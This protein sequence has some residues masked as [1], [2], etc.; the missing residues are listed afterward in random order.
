ME[1]K[2]GGVGWGVG[3]AHGLPTSGVPQTV[4]LALNIL[5]ELLFYRKT[6][7]KAEAISR[8]WILGFLDTWVLEPRGRR[9]VLAIKSQRVCSSGVLYR[10][11][12]LCF[13]RLGQA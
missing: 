13:L 6:G 9:K 12:H 10:E 8:S 3:Y 2:G 11:A 7:S 1:H 5:T 4:L